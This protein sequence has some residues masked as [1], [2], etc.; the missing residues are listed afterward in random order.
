M[1]S[2]VNHGVLA[3]ALA[4]SEV[5]LTHLRCHHSVNWLCKPGLNLLVGANGCG[6]TTLLESVYMMAHGR[7][8]RQARDPFLLKNGEK[9]F[10][11]QGS[12]KRFGPMHLCVSGGK[13]KT[14]IRLQ[15]RDIQRR[16]DV[17][18]SFP[19][20]VD[21]PQ[22]R[23]LVDGVA[24]ERRRWLDNLAMI[25]FESVRSHYQHY[26]RALMQRSRLLRQRASSEE[27][28]VW[29]QQIVK[30]GEPIVAIR[31]RLLEELNALLVDETALTEYPLSLDLKVCN[32]QREVW[33]AR[34]ADRREEDRRMGSLR[35]GPH[36]D[37]LNINFQGRE[38]RNSGS[39]GQQRLAAIALKMAEC[40]LWMCYRRLIP[41]LLMDDCLEALDSERQV[42]VLER[43]QQSYGQ[44]LMTAPA[45][46][47]IPTHIDIDVQTFTAQGLNFIEEQRTDVGSVNMSAIEVV[48]LEEAA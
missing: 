36:S 24:G 9:S 32:Y 26:M 44:V 4:V 6:K 19:V 12:W 3:T 43:L 40:G 23:R 38:I 45:G 25:C 22:G 37:V 13:G 10:L 20:L 35:F 41:V 18:E 48:E 33:L 42:R 8:F 39:R 29:E 31:K 27:L 17:S 21:A 1:Q 34:L 14:S 7:S 5:K 46:I 28:M 30:H 2:T 11:I 47:T 16:K 15:G